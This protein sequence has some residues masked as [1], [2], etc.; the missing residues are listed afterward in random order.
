MKQPCTIILTVALAVLLAT[1]S[2]PALAGAALNQDIGGS[3]FF[4]TF[5]DFP[6]KRIPTLEMVTP[7]VSILDPF[8]SAV[9]KV[10]CFIITLRGGDPVKKVKGKYNSELI[11]RDNRTG[12]FESF[13]IGSGR[14]KTNKEGRAMFDLD[15]PTAIFADGFESGDVSAWSYTR[16]DFTNG[17]KLSVTNVDCRNA[18]AGVEG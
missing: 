15:I 17:K 7:I 6:A 11:V 3:N 12:D 2:I 4:A 1:N 13:E 9:T 16:T 18:L 10:T 5:P 8:D 14:F